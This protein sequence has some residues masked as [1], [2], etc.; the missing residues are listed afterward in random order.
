MSELLSGVLTF[1][2]RAIILALDVTA[3][4]SDAKRFARWATGSSTLVAIPVELKVLTP[5]AQR[6]LAEAER[7][8][9]FLS[10]P[11]K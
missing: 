11:R 8:H 1:I 5:A 9:R 7:R 10:L 3:S 6:A 2:V 4:I